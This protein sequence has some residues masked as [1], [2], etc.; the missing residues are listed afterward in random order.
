MSEPCLLPLHVLG[1]LTLHQGGLAGCG[2]DRELGS[3]TRGKR[4]WGGG[5]RPAVL[6]F[7][8]KLAFSAFPHSP[9]FI[10][11]SSS[12]PSEV[13]CFCPPFAASRG[14]QVGQT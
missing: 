10:L 7:C 13:R 14:S 6:L 11:F 5:G 8:M 4:G 2:H 12:S 3:E 9:D 1:R